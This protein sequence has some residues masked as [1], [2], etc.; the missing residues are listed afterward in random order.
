[1]PG[2]F[3][4]LITRLFFLHIL[5]MISW[6]PHVIAALSPTQVLEKDLTKTTDI[7]KWHCFKASQVKLENLCET[8]S[9]GPVSEQGT[10]CGVSFEIID[11]NTLYSFGIQKA[12]NG[13]EFKNIQNAWEKKF[14]NKTPLCLMG[15]FIS[16]SL[17]EKSKYQPAPQK[18]LGFTWEVL[19]NKDHCLSYFC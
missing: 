5:G 2:K 10:F 3:S 12:I 14:K 13:D 19:R 9:E 15:S 17:L 4:F 11:N 18:R 6:S 8:I 16:E 7:A 1:M